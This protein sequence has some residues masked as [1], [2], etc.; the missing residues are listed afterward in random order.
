MLRNLADQMDWNR[1]YEINAVAALSF[2]K[3]A[4]T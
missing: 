3:I 4:A 1:A 2:C